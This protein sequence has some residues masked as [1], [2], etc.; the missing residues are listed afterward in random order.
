MDIYDT[1]IEPA[2]EPMGIAGVHALREHQALAITHGLNNEN[3]FLAL[4]TG[5]GKSL[6]FQIS[7]IIQAR[8]EQ[9][10]TVVLQPALEII[11]SQVKALSAHG[12]DVEIFSSLTTSEE[13]NALAT[14]LNKDA[15]RPA[16]IYTTSDSFFGHYHYV[17]TTLYRKEALARIVMDEE[18]TICIGRT[19]N[20]KHRLTTALSEGLS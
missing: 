16:L 8:H 17:F 14:R 4:A 10:V 18:Y 3:L 12:I 6:C 20:V 5:A 11:T 1:M 9:Q 7:A 15:Y 13:R 2:F 19:L